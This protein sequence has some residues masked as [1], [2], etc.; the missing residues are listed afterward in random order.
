MYTHVE[1]LHAEYS[2]NKGLFQH[3]N[4]STWLLT[5]STANPILFLKKKYHCLLNKT[6]RNIPICNEI[7]S[8]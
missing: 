6:L 2:A 3:H 4:V 1:L 5:R 8:S 7:S